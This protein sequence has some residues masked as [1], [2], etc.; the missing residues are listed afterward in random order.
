MKNYE[1]TFERKSNGDWIWR[2]EFCRDF[3]EAILKALLNCPDDCRVQNI[4]FIGEE[5]YSA[6][7][8]AK[9]SALK[10]FK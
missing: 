4:Q 2:R 5:F 7:D 8:K 10:N 3:Q 9:A 1:L 6:G